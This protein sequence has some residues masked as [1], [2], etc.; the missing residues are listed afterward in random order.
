[1]VYLGIVL[2]LVGL[3][4]ISKTLGWLTPAKKEDVQPE[5]ARRV[6]RIISL[7][8]S[9]IALLAGVYVLFGVFGHKNA[10]APASPTVVTSP[11]AYPKV[12]YWDA[13]VK[14]NLYKQCLENGKNTAAKYPTIVEDY[15]KCATAKIAEA[16]DAEMYEKLMTKPVD[17]QKQE[18]GPIVESCVK[19]MN[20]LIE[21]SQESSGE[22]PKK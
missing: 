2:C 15:C 13:A 16:M 1:M 9:T 7:S 22:T 12:Y 6:D 21:L 19:I 14:E 3:Y 20:K 18:I 10:S 11:S 5:E 17:Q 4:Y 8:L